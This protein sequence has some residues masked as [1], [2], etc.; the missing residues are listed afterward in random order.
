M[1]ERLVEAVRGERDY[2]VM[3]LPFFADFYLPA[4][5]KNRPSKLCQSDS[6]CSLII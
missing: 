5:G 6:S 1:V 3:V 4:L 2:I